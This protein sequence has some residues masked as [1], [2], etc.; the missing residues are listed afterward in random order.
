MSSDET[1]LFRFGALTDFVSIAAPL[2]YTCDNFEDVQVTTAGALCGEATGIWRSH[3]DPTAT[4]ATTA[5]TV[6]V[7]FRTF[8]MGLSTSRT[9][10]TTAVDSSSHAHLSGK[11]CSLK[12]LED[13]VDFLVDTGADKDARKNRQRKGSIARSDHSLGNCNFSVKVVTA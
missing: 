3:R 12:V 9:D 13:I 7:Y 2:W 10:Y 6:N 11:L 1:T 8:L 4:T 5:T